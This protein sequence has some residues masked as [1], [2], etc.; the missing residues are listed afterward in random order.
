L[1]INPA[2]ATLTNIFVSIDGIVTKKNLKQNGKPQ[3]SL[4]I[5]KNS[6]NTTI[7]ENKKFKTNQHTTKQF[8]KKKKL[9][10]LDFLS[11]IEICRSKV[12]PCRI[13]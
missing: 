7:I 5:G 6:K 13:L 12:N 2:Q 1:S 9:R 4:K 11:C 3:K 10:S 8:K